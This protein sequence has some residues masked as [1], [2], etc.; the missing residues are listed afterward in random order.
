MRQIKYIVLHCTGGPAD[1][2]TQIIRDGWKK[3]GWKNVGYHQ[4]IS[5]D[6]TIECLA[7]DEKVTNGVAGHNANSIH[8]CYK[9]GWNYNTKKGEDTRTPAQLFAMR[10]LVK[11]YKA[12]YPNAKILGH[13][14]FSKDTNKNGKVDK[15][16]WTKVCP[17]FDV[18]EWLKLEGI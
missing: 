1:Q 6:G 8:I 16:E 4:I 13:R 14:D 10:T 9:G 11:S 7:E 18:S 12:K 15:W 5:G 3:K 17:S 2:S